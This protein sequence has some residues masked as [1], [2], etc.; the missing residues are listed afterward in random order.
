[1][2]VRVCTRP[3]SRGHGYGTMLVCVCNCVRVMLCVTQPC[4]DVGKYSFYCT[5]FQ[6][7]TPRHCVPHPPSAL[8]E[9]KTEKKKKSGVDAKLEGGVNCMQAQKGGC[10]RGSRRNWSV[11]F[12]FLCSIIYRAPSWDTGERM[13]C[14]NLRAVLDARWLG[15]IEFWVGKW[16]VNQWLVHSTTRVRLARETNKPC[17]FSMAELGWNWVCMYCDLGFVLLLRVPFVAMAYI[18]AVCEEITYMARGP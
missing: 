13:M 18:I 11:I 3:C 4:M 9:N 10:E 1:M 15:R 17:C 2:Y 14:K 12:F 16:L 6:V 5:L 8:A 7:N